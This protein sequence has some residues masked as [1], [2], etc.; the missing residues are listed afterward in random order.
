[1]LYQ[2]K[3]PFIFTLFGASGDLARLKIFPALYELASQ[4][5]LP[6]NYTI[7]GFARTPKRREEFQEEFRESVRKKMKETVDEAILNNLVDHVFYFT[8]QY[9]DHSSFVAYSSF[10]EEITNQTPGLHLAYFSVPPA[11]FPDIIQGLVAAKFPLRDLRLIIEKPFGNNQA[12]AEELF[13]FVAQHIAEKQ[14]YLLDHYLGKSSVQS[15]LHLRHNNRILNSMMKGREVANIQITAFEDIGI[16]ERVGYFENTGIIKDMIQSHLLQT[17]ALITMSI[18]ITESAD[19]IH[20][21]RRSILSAVQAPQEKHDVVLGQY[22]SYRKEKGVPSTS[23]TETFVGLRLFI[24]RESWHDVPIYLRTGKKTKVKHTFVVIELKKFAFQG[25]KEEPNRLVIELQPEERISIKLQNRQGE[26][27]EYQEVSTSDSLACTIEGCLTDHAALILDA[28][29][30]DKTNFLSFPEIIETWRV[31]DGILDTIARHHLP[32]EQYADG[33]FG[34]Q[35]HYHLP[36]RDGFRWY[37]V[38]A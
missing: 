12:S 23:N 10:I 4:R 13:H 5:R 20:R 21:E 34:P 18:P 22:Q 7:V 19:G 32:V 2:I 14:V 25:E 31:T 16:A 3:K 11:V 30:G 9:R 27:N 38:H 33:T 15:I 24:D 36:E 17:L 29:K 35:S 6:Q 37:D 8:G 26:R 28:I 1:M